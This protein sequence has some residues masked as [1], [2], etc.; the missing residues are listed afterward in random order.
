TTEITDESIDLSLRRVGWQRK[1]PFDQHVIAASADGKLKSAF[2]GAEG[3]DFEVP[4]QA[5]ESSR[6][7]VVSSSQFLTNPFAYSGNGPD[8]GHHFQMFG[9]VGGDRQ[10][11]AVA[12][13]YAQR[14][15]TNTILAVKNTMDWITGDQDLLAI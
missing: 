12:G 7:L 9:N 4:E 8:L 14:Y 2:A 10:L 3:G 1:P 5:P 15:L 13:P 11:L 6:V